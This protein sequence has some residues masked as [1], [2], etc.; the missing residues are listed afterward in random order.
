MGLRLTRRFQ[1]IRL[2]KRIFDSDAS[3][4]D[5]A[6]AMCWIC[7]L[8]AD[9]MQPCHTGS[10]Y[11][12]HVFPEGDRGAN[13][14]RVKQGRNLHALWDG[15]LGR[16]FDEGDVSRRMNEIKRRFDPENKGLKN[17][18]VAPPREELLS[19]EFVKCLIGEGRHY[20]KVAVY[21]PEVIEPITVAHR[22]GGGEIQEIN[23][24]ERYLSR[25]GD[26]AKSQAYKAS[27]LLAK[28]LE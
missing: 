13:S 24:S 22:S 6:I 27:Y 1:A 18:P 10:L 25:A 11:V 4:A 7:H 17:F 20:G 14:I 28:L 21:M 23:L 5:K 16:R 12:E 15:L 3:E 9:I 19:T 8:M 2:S 26:I